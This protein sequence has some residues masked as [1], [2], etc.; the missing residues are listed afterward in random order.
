[1]LYIINRQSCRAINMTP[2]EAWTGKK[3]DL[4]HIKI[5][6]TTAMVHVPGQKRRKL[7]PK[8]VECKVVGFDINTKGYRLYEKSKRRV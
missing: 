4:S 5:F 3:P 1:M 8:A 6:G 7:D 2:Q